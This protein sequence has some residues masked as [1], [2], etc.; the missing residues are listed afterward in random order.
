MEITR[1]AD[2]GYAALRHV[3]S[4]TGQP[5]SVLLPRSTDEVVEAI[6]IVRSSGRPFSVRSGGHGISSI[7]TNDGGDVIDLRWMASVEHRGGTHV[8]IGPGARWSAVAHEL[9]PLGLA[10]SSGDS[11]DVGVGGLA[12]TGGVGL[13]GRAH[14]LTIDR[15]R[16]AEIVTAD[17][18]VHRVSET[19][20]PDLFWAVRGAGANFG[21]VTSFDFEAA[22]TSD[23]VQATVAYQPTDLAA[24]LVAWGRTVEE[25]ASEVSAF[26]YIGA[27]PRPFAQATVVYAG[28]D[29]G[30][31]VPELER[32]VRLP[33]TAGQRSMVVPYSAVPLTSGAPHTGQQR[34]A[35][36][37]GLAVHLDGDLSA[38]IAVLLLA[39]GA[40]MVQ[41]R[42]VGGA[43]NDVDPDATAYAHRHQN[44]SVTA[45]SVDGGPAFHRAWEPV[46]ERMDGMYLSF[47]S[48]HRAEAVAEAFPPRT[49]A[50]LRTLKARFDPDD[51]FDQNFDVTETARSD[52]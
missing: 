33:G 29:L 40:E 46:H 52:R 44:F 36:H 8:R 4:R 6:G 25:A 28:D 49:L 23:V 14:G 5:G 41:I 3:Y 34:A 10:I 47:E 30:V 16:S 31:A 15:L 1:P 7:A 19:E 43:I 37:T 17:G 21:V 51:V 42:S 45:V 20:D 13:M 39:G 26:L 32:F 24:F 35:A 27:G 22:E 48:D 9:S 11:G 12:T 50:R 38:R 2:R 18:R